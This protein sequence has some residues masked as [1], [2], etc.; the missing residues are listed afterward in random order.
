[1]FQA[2]QATKIKIFALIAFLPTF[3]NYFTWDCIIPKSLPL[4]KMNHYHHQGDKEL[5]PL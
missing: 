2:I 1:M 5:I 4:L 3:I